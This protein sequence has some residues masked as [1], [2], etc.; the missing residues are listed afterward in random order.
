[1]LVSYPG[2]AGMMGLACVA[3]GIGVVHPSR[4]WCAASSSPPRWC[5]RSWIS[6]PFGVFSGST[7]RGHRPFRPPRP[8]PAPLGK[9][10]L[11]AVACAAKGSLAG[12]CVAILLVVPVFLMMSAP[13]SLYARFEPLIPGVLVIVMLMLVISERDDRRPHRGIERP[14]G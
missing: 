1:M 6:F 2:I 13:V 8:P 3:F 9:G 14:P 7:G 4:C 11:D 5:I 12:A 10:K